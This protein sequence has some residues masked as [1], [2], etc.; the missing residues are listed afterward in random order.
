MARGTPAVA[1]RL[2]NDLFHV[3]LFVALVAQLADI[4]DRLEFM[5]SHAGVAG[6][7]FSRR[8]RRVNEFVRTHCRM[9]FCRDAGFLRRR[10]CC[11]IRTQSVPCPAESDNDK[12]ENCEEQCRSGLPHGPCDPLLQTTAIK[13]DDLNAASSATDKA[14]LQTIARSNKKLERDGRNAYGFR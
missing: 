4:A 12:G 10:C 9:A 5:L 1:D 14:A 6:I 11:G 8:N 3:P 7:A 13:C 2:M